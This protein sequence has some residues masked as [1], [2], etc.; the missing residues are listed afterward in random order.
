MRP[1][2][3]LEENRVNET[4]SST[5]WASL[6]ALDHLVWYG[7]QF[8]LQDPT[9]CGEFNFELGDGT[10]LSGFA[11]RDW[12]EA[13]VDLKVTAMD[14]KSAYKQLPLM[15]LSPLDSDEAVISLWNEVQQDVDVSSAPRS[16]LELQLASTTSCG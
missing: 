5:E 13:G 15:L 1:I 12:L 4:F 11:H 9:R 3:D 16:H 14:L 2:D 6:Y 10:Q 8:S 7:F